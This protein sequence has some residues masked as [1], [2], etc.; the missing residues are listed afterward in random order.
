MKSHNLA[1][2]FSTLITSLKLDVV[3]ELVAVS[4]KT[5]SC[6]SVTDSKRIRLLA[7]GKATE[8]VVDDLRGCVK[9][10]EIFRNLFTKPASS[11]T[12]TPS[13]SLPAASL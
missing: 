13:T 9:A 5:E 3:V 2:S 6:F 8:L 10:V 1:V 12:G 11:S 4:S 7:L